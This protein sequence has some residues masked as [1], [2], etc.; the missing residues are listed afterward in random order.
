MSEISE[1]GR[2]PGCPRKGQS[3]PNDIGEE[4]GPDGSVVGDLFYRFLK[5]Q[6]SAKKTSY[7]CGNIFSAVFAVSILARFLD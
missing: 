3:R 7:L 2:S 4:I 6:K 5:L 1:R